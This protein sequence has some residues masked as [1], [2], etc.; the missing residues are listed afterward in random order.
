M[1]V[2][3]ANNAAINSFDKITK[4][5]DGS[6]DLYFGPPGAAPAGQESN[7]VD[8]SASK[9]WWVWFRFYGPTQ[10]FFDK[11]WQLPDF[12]KL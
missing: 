9:G 1:T 2:N 8:T 10:P 6:W 12:E 7:W 11:S 4:N 5:A 3:K